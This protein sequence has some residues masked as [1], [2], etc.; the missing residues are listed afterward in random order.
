MTSVIV[1][2]FLP[3]TSGFR[4]SNSW[5]SVP[6]FNLQVGPVSVPIGNASN[7][8]CGGM[9][10]AA[11]DFHEARV[12]PP[13][14]TVAPASGPLFDYV[15]R[16]LLDSFDLPFGPLR[17][18][19]LMNPT[20]PDHDTWLGPHGRAWITINQEW[21]VIRGDLDAGFL[22]PLG[23]IEIKSFNPGDLGHNHQVL[24][25]GYDLNGSNLTIR[26]Y[27]PNYHD[28][29]GV[30]LS[31]DTSHPAHTTTVTHSRG[32]TVY[33]F[34]RTGYSFSPPAFVEPWH[35]MGGLVTSRAAVELNA[36]GRLEVFARGTDNAPYHNWQVSPGGGWSGWGSLGGLI[37]SDLAVGRNADG[38][39][40]VFARG[41]DNALYHNWQVSPGG[42][43]SGWG[44]L[45]GLITSNPAVFANADGRLEV[46]VRGTDNAL[47]HNWQL[48][49]GGG[50]SGW[51]S[52]GGGITSDPAVAR[53]ADGRL[54]VFVRGTDNA[55]YHNWQVSPGGG[56]SG[57]D[58]LGGVLSGD[59]AVARNADGR[60]E[61]FMRASDGELAHRWQ[62][63]PNGAW[64]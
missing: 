22:S 29:D 51:G 52:L 40:E 31:L 26:V 30:T 55:L 37:T 46:F 44:S 48:S 24:A 12:M 10:F 45:G 59:P 57:W 15:V 58:R 47:Y 20:L 38:R 39:L 19:E 54:E 14:D 41:T 32:D 64:A 1:P 7:G 34:F 21:P 56:W 16:R 9:V 5:P 17:Y 28:D 18:M 33:C 23:L 3:S 8:L 60:L 36:D 53:N 11:R 13:P 62:A 4:F 35:P 25:Y 61:V 49:P 6:L 50:W 42:G 63:T 2:G 43:W 27:D